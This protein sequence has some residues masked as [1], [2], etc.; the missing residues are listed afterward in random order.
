[1]I[2]VDSALQGFWKKGLAEVQSQH[3]SLS[4]RQVLARQANHTPDFGEV[5]P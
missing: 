3:W 5:K 1:M 4:D 2:D